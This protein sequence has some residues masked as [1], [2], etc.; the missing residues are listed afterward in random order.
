MDDSVLLQFV[1]VEETFTIYVA[2]VFP[3]VLSA[4]VSGKMILQKYDYPTG[5]RMQIMLRP[6]LLC[7]PKALKAHYHGYLGPAR[8]GVKHRHQSS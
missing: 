5:V 7:Q 1:G 6:A 8:R 2:A 4:V 3:H